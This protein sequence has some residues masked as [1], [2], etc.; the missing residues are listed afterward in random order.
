VKKRI[1][2]TGG[3]GFLGSHLCARFRSRNLKSAPLE[4]KEKTNPCLAVKPEMVVGPGHV[5][6]WANRFFSG[7]SVNF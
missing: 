7:F 4:T 6:A 5:T 1:L 3:A 2:V